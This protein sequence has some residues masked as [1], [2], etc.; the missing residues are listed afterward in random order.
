MLLLSLLLFILRSIKPQPEPLDGIWPSFFVGDDGLVTQ[1]ALSCCNAEPPL[2]QLVDRSGRSRA[3][4][5]KFQ[6]YI[7]WNL[8][9]KSCRPVHGQHSKSEPSKLQFLTSDRT[10]GIANRCY[11]PGC[12][13]LLQCL[14]ISTK[15][16]Q[17]NG[18]M[19]IQNLPPKKREQRRKLPSLVLMVVTKGHVQEEFD[20]SQN[21]LFEPPSQSS[22]ENRARPSCLINLSKDVEC[23]V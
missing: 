6:L 10:D 20:K 2:K 21:H 22:R 19:T 9:L 12:K 11:D 7:M 1:V 18:P 17:S 16:C 4:S 23:C 13:G 15:T 8:I 3:N 14:L 5:C